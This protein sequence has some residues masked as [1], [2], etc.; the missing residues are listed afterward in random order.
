MEKLKLKDLSLQNKRVL[1]RVDFNVPLRSD[2]SIAD[3]TRIRASLPSIR[4]ILE[5][6]PAILILMSHLG[7][8]QGKPNAQESLAPCSKCLSEL[9]EQPVAMASECVG[10]AVEAL[11]AHAAPG[12]VVLLE[13]LRFHPGEEEPGKE[14]GFVEKLAKLGDVYI[15]DAFGCAHRAHASTALIASHFPHKAAMGLLIEHELS[16]LAPLLHNPKRPFHAIIGGAKVSSKAGVLKNLLPRIDAL[17]I[18]GGMAF[19]FLKAQS[20]P[21]GHSLCDDKDVPTAQELLKAAK[22]KSLPLYLPLDSSA[23]GKGGKQSFFSEGIPDG[24]IGMDIGPKTLESWTR[25][26]ASAATVFWNG[27]VG[28]FEKPPY[29]AGTRTLAQFL[30]NCQATVIIGGGDSAAAI[31]SLGLANQF[32]HLSTGGGASLEF[33]E[34][35]HL[36]GIDALSDK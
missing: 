9:L 4:K 8:P 13:N 5:Q 20:I 25:T 27:P 1:M 31:Q 11:V 24:W 12:S 10:P 34:F 23:S 30:A 14:D 18:G 3:D 28:V 21:I 26:L 2:G 36:P 17:Y 29:D 35:G 7:R 16:F 15:N 32:S 22:E 19:P 6:R 33:L